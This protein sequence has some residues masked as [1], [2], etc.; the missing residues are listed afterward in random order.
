MKIY[1]NRWTY[2]LKSGKAL[3]EAIDNDDNLATLEALKACWQEIHDNYPDSYDDYDLERDLA[4][5]ENEMDN[6]MNFDD[7]DLTDEDIEDN[8]N[9]MLDNLYDFCDGYNI[10]VEL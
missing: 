4:D 8:I 1:G 9:Y 5:I 3:R 10:W 6:I 2:T 7:Y